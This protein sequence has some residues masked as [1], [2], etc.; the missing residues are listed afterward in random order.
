[1]YGYAKEKNKPQS[2]VYS[3]EQEDNAMT[4]REAIAKFP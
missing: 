1:M 4:E 2:S 3:A